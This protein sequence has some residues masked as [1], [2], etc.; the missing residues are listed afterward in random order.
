MQDQLIHQP[1]A[2]AD[3]RRSLDGDPAS[4]L[5]DLVGA[6]TLGS[7]DRAHEAYRSAHRHGIAML[8]AIENYLSAQDWTK[9]VNIKHLKVFGTLASLARDIDEAASDQIMA[10]CLPASSDRLFRLRW[11]SIRSFSIANF[12]EYS[13][14]GIRVYVA[15]DLKDHEVKAALIDEWLGCLPAEDF[16]GV[17]RLYVISAKDDMAYA[18]RY[19]PIL[20]VVTIVWNPIADAIIAEFGKLAWIPQWLRY[21]AEKHALYH[22]IGHHVH[23][24]TWG[25]D[26]EQEQQAEQYAWR[27]L[28]R[29]HPFSWGLLY[30]VVRLISRPL[31]RRIFGRKRQSRPS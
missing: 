10:R 6:T 1:L 26:P 9:C 28:I 22:E 15:R 4:L 12:A 7:Y 16:R 31:R 30:W 20:F 21:F 19:V 27:T 29:S 8:R 11:D 2:V 3:T 25:Q 17:E 5:H 14:R 23:R 24:H 18:G 13:V